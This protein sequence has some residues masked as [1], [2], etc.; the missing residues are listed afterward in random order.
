MPV[1]L[2][3]VSASLALPTPQSATAMI[4]P[5]LVPLFGIEANIYST[6]QPGSCVGFNNINIPCTCPP[7]R[8][9]FIDRLQQF[10]SA[11]TAFGIPIAFPTD[12]S[13]QSQL[14]RIDACIDTL[15]SFDNTTPGEGCPIAAA[16]NFS[17]TQASLLQLL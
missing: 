16:P 5:A 4:N 8:D 14:D 6:T 15:Q 9:E 10:V 7:P 2:L 1:I 13:I 11:G 3:L 12:D 17:A